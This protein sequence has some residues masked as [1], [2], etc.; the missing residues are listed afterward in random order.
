MKLQNEIKIVR[1]VT[2]EEL[3]C[4]VSSDLNK[5]VN[6]L[7]DVAILI[8]TEANS[9]GLAPFMGYSTAYDSK[10]GMDVEDKFI[11]FVVDPVETLKKQYQTMFAKILT[12]PSKILM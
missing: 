9:L 12:P 10:E 4:T 3:L 8:P 7:T 6:T 5:T 1:L 2:G 11:M